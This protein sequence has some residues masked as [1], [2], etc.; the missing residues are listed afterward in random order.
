M[1]RIKERREERERRPYTTGQKWKERCDKER[2]GNRA[3][4]GRQRRD[5]RRRRRRIMREPKKK[6]R[7]RGREI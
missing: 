3:C 5:G 4:S 7:D 1:T 2:R 6:M